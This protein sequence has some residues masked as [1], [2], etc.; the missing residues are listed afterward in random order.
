[1]YQI[2]RRSL[3]Q[4]SFQLNNK[5]ML[6]LSMKSVCTDIF[7]KH[8]CCNNKLNA[9][10]CGCLKVGHYMMVPA[11]PLALQQHFFHLPHD[12]P[13]YQMKL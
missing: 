10:A 4:D 7:P 8:A 6:L 3:S 9:D 11:S 2:K 13:T 5:M 12:V 1:M